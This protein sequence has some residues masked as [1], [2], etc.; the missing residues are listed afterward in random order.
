MQP[1]LENALK[2]KQFQDDIIRELEG[3]GIYTIEELK[4]FKVRTFKSCS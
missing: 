2:A 1:E 4:Y 3:L